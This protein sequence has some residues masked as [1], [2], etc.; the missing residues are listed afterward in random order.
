M[1]YGVIVKGSY[2]LSKIFAAIHDTQQDY[3]WLISECECNISN[4]AEEAYLKQ[5]YC[6]MT[7]EELIQMVREV[8]CQW[9]WGVLSGIPKEYTLEDVLQHQPLPYANGYHGFWHNPISL[10]HPLAEVE[11]VPWDSTYTLLISKNVKT[12]SDFRRAFPKSQDLREYN[13]A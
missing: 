8:D 13:T 5:G 2:Y 6:W 12:V 1:I 10:Q 4:P 9:I 7:G 11:L 3:N